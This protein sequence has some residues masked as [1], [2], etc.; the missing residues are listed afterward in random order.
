MRKMM[1]HNKTIILGVAI[2]LIM[3]FTACSSGDCSPNSTFPNIDDAKIPDVLEI[4]VGTLGD[5]Y[6]SDGITDSPDYNSVLTAT[7]NGTTDTDYTKLMEHYK[8][9]S[10]GTDE[11]GSLIFDWGVLQVTTGDGSIS[12]NALIK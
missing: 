5:C 3:T 11:N 7:F 12:I 1:K 6:F 4:T 9:A 10:T 8:S 2:A